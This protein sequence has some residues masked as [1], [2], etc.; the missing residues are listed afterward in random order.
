MDWQWITAPLIGAIIGYITNDIAL[1][2]L[3]RPYNEKYI[4]RFHIPLTP[5]LIPKSKKR[6]ARSVRALLEAELF[7]IEVLQEALLSEEM[8]AKIENIVENGLEKLLQEEKT[9]RM[10]LHTFWQEKELTAFENDVKRK[11]CIFIMEKILESDIDKLAAGAAM[12]EVKERMKNT[13]AAPLLLF[14]DEKRSIS[15]EE[16]LA[17]SIREMVATHAPTALYTMLE[18]G[19]HTGL[20]TPIG[21]LLA[22][23]HE[24]KEAVRAFAMAQYAQFV[25]QGLSA[26]L[27][28]VELGKIVED[29]I[30]GMDSAELEKNVLEIAK[31]ELR[32]IVWLGG[33]LGGLI[34]LINLFF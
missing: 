19:L 5:G 33:L 25:K 12:A 4:G 8:L 23:Q 6:L 16:K 20:D 26:V 21:K 1:R 9:L 34:G 10:V 31:K 18:E 14:L 22:K 27:E 3:F 11:F 13:A 29:K 17:Q 28:T 7:N 24:H 30:N 2:M 15:M 32:T